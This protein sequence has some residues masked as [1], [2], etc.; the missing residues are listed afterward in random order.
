MFSYLPPLAD[1]PLLAHS[2][3]LT[4]LAI[5]CNPPGFKA[6]VSRIRVQPILTMHFLLFLL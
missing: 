5:T 2:R 1:G 6:L 3:S 4:K